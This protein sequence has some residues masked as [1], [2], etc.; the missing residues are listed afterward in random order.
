MPPTSLPKPGSSVGRP[1]DAFPQVAKETKISPLPK[2]FCIAGERIRTLARA[3]QAAVL[4][5]LDA[6]TFRIR[7]QVRGLPVT[8]KLFMDS[9]GHSLGYTQRQAKGHP[10]ELHFINPALDLIRTVHP[11]DACTGF[12]QGGGQWIIACRDGGIHCFS[13]TGELLWTWQVPRDRHFES[14]VFAV[15]ANDELIFAAEGLY[16]YAL[17]PKGRLLWDWELPHRHEQMHRLS[18][19]IGGAGRANRRALQTLGLG[20]SAGPDEVRQAYR[21]MARLT[22]PDFNPADP[23]ACDRFRAVREAYEAMQREQPAAGERGGGVQVTISLMINGPPVTA[24]ITSLRAEG[25]VIAIGTSEGEVYLC[26]QDAEVLAYHESLGRQC[27][28]SILLKGGGL[29]AAFCYPRLYRFGC[30]TTAA[31]E[32]LPEYSVDL[33]QRGDDVLVWGWK[34][35]WFFDR[36]AR[37]KG[38]MA[39]DRQIDGVRASCGETVVLAGRLF[40]I[41]HG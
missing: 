27:V 40:A 10:S 7:N 5:D 34:T 30:G 18:V 29:D 15:A 12:A 1:Q 3:N 9:D 8:H 41:P 24:R 11:A 39:L 25:P 31:S 33:V 21:R 16:L 38:G 32:E 2:I 36:Q 20:E 37:L 22:H 14:P 6:S 17:S 23:T 13:G 28:S 35:L 4:T 26:D 19:P